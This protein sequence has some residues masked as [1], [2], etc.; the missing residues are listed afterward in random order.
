MTM[1][2]EKGKKMKM[3]TLKFAGMDVR[4]TLIGDKV[5]WSTRDIM[6]I[7][8][9]S[10]ETVYLDPGGA[11]PNEFR[12]LAPF[13]KNRKDCLESAL[14]EEALLYTLVF[15]DTSMAIALQ[16]WVIHIAI[17]IIVKKW[18]AR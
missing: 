3:M 15:S 12:K 18:G 9:C 8:E 16:K 7:L 4:L 6:R 17:P 11:V 13:D 10:G 2:P 1:K 5:Y 14:S